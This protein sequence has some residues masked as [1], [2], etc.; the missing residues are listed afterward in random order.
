MAG[1]ILQ[2]GDQTF[3]SVVFVAMPEARTAEIVH[4]DPVMEHGVMQADLFPCRTALWSNKG[5][6]IEDSVL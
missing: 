4:N 1:R 5:P 3:G 2:S 6:G